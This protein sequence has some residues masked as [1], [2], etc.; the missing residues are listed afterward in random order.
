[1]L[2]G[3]MPGL[4]DTYKKAKS[5]FTINCFIFKPKLGIFMIN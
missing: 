3:D 4:N 2:A 1:M 5:P